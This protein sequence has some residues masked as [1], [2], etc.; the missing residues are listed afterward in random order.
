MSEIIRTEFLS[1]ELNICLLRI[2]GR[3]PQT[4]ER[5][6]QGICG[7]FNLDS[8]SYSLRLAGS[9][10]S[11]DPLADVS[12]LEGDVLVIEEAFKSNVTGQDHDPCFK[13]T[14]LFLYREVAYITNLQ[15]ATELYGIPLRR[16]D[17]ISDLEYEILFVPL[18]HLAEMCSGVTQQVSVTPQ[19]LLKLTGF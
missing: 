7:E 2:L 9:K 13:D 14:E 11:V 6:I 10:A 5:L 12:L 16:L 15:S 1:N 18:H 19:A 8:D 17:Y 3:S 4:I